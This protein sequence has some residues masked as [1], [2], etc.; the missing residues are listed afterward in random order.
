M[1]PPCAPT[2]P[3]ATLAESAAAHKEEP[4]QGARSGRSRFKASCAWMRPQSGMHRAEY[5]RA[6]AC[7]RGQIPRGAPLP[8][9]GTRPESPGPS[10]ESKCYWV[11]PGCGACVVTLLVGASAA[12]AERER[13][14]GA[15]SA[16][17][18]RGMRPGV[19]RIAR[20]T[21]ALVG[22]PARSHPRRGPC[23]ALRRPWQSSA[24]GATRT[25]E[26]D[27]SFP[28]NIVAIKLSFPAGQCRGTL[29]AVT[30]TRSP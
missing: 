8:R 4:T 21:N 19:A 6:C 27:Q 24:P 23:S 25:A 2:R 14:G 29:C 3:E 7:L 10:K 5:A 16:G 1:Q 18:G 13:A 12:S 30:V 9:C 26:L 17:L 11:V 15:G 22:T 20:R 28:G